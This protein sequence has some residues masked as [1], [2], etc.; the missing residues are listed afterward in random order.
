MRTVRVVVTDRLLIAGAQ[1]LRAVLDEYVAHYNQYRPRRAWNLR[2][3]DDV[4]ADLA[5]A[6]TGAGQA[7]RPL[8]AT[9]VS[10]SRA[11]QLRQG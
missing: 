10:K 4:I 2:A 11:P 3:L 8:S 9:A 7:S 5:A 6:G 1:H